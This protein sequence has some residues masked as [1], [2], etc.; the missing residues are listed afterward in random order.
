MAHRPNQ[1]QRGETAGIEDASLG[2][3]PCSVDALARQHGDDYARGY[4]AGYG[5]KAVAAVRSP[6][7]PWWRSISARL[8]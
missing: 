6:G 4:T 8:R 3:S 5:E 7:R 1:F 2:L